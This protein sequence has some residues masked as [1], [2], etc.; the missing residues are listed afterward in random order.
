MFFN[1]KLCVRISNQ[2]IDYIIIIQPCVSPCSY[3]LSKAGAVS[4]IVI[5]SLAL[6][7]LPKQMSDQWCFWMVSICLLSSKHR[8][9]KYLDYAIDRKKVVGKVTFIYG[10]PVF[11]HCILLWTKY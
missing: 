10:C 6:V 1:L 11:V 2:T 4:R 8:F 9:I 5:H 3:F 7:M